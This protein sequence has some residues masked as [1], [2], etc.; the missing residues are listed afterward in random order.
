MQPGRIYFLVFVDVLPPL[1][2]GNPL[3]KRELTDVFGNEES[4]GLVLFRSTETR[5][6]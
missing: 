2:A 4:S 5:Y 6:E 3:L 1:E